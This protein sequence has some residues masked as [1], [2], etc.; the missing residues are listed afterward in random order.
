M[1]NAEYGIY[2]G[3][4]PLRSKTCIYILDYL[5]FIV[6]RFLF[7]CLLYLFGKITGIVNL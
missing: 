1:R 4:S 2:G 3:F 7:F 6:L 5:Y